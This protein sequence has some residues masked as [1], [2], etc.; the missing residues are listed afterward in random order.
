MPDLVEPQSTSPRI[1]AWDH[2]LVAP[3]LE[4]ARIEHALGAL[5]PL[6]VLGRVESAYRQRFRL[7][8]WQYM[9]AVNDEL[10]VAFVVGTA[11]FASNGFV[12]A[13]ELATGRIHQRF[14]IAPLMLGTRLAPSS[15]AGAHSFRRGR[16][17]A[18][19]IENR[20]GGR[21][22]D[23]RIDAATEAGGVLR[24]ALRF[25]SKPAD[26][27]LAICVPLPGGRW[28]YT[29]KFGAF[30][31][32]GDLT[33]S[34][35]AR[36]GSRARDGRRIVFE[37][38]KAYGTLDFTKMYALRHAVWRWVAAC[39]RSRRGAVV[40]INLVDPTPD[41]P[42]SENALWIDGKREPLADVHLDIDVPADPASGWRA[43]A[44]SV[45]LEMRAVAHVEQRLDVPLVRHRL[46]HVVGAF[47][48]R[49]RTASGQIHELDSL[50]GIA[51]DNDT[52][53]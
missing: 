14:A 4:D 8:S 22:F 48:G 25:A 36:S 7:K 16:E 38:G 19:S 15:V 40:G 11:G 2:P 49:V 52:W 26:D 43:T 33:I 31:V 6:P 17:L 13:A 47:R 41:A 37:P 53:W 45:D 50:V 23:A 30:D 46:R 28:N 5:A 3:N 44:A 10:F 9:T 39:G 29:H 35:P 51:E 20:D 21:A 1:A 18:I 34:E 24:G 27:H 12:Y 42:I 32:T